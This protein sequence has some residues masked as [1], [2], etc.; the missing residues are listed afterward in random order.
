MEERAELKQKSVG[1]KW[2]SYILWLLIDWAVVRRWKA[3][4]SFFLLSSKVSKPI[5]ASISSRGVRDL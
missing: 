1:V 3:E 4:P 2:E 5:M